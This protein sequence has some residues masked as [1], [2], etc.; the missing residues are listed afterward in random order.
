MAILLATGDA[1]LEWHVLLQWLRRDDDAG[2]VRRGVANQAFQLARVLQKPLVHRIFLGLGKLWDHRNGLIQG[3]V[4]CR[5]HQL[6][7]V[8]D[9]AQRDVKGTPH[10]TNDR[11]RLHRAEGDDLG[12][13]ILPVLLA[14]VF[15]DPIA[16]SVV[17]V[18]IDIGHRDP[19]AVEEALED[20]S[21]L[22]WIEGRDAEPVTH[23][24]AGGGSAP[25]SN[26]DTVGPRITDEVTDDE[27]VRCVAHVLDH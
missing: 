4:E 15:D 20:E 7:K 12:D 3:H 10:V 11:A 21:V 5:R 16:I 18:D 8:V 9:L 19:L 1:R 24:A 2:R 14:H 22:Q 27:E 17:K 23:D 26:R 6:R 13:V 25:G